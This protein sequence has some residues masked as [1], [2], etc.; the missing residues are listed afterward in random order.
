MD[1]HWQFLPCLNY[2]L[3]SKECVP[4]S[5]SGEAR[6]WVE[7]QKFAWAG[8][9]SDIRSL[10]IMASYWGP[11]MLD[12]VLGVQLLHVSVS[13]LTL[14][15]LANS[16][17]TKLS[18]LSS[19][20]KFRQNIRCTHSCFIPFFCSR[21]PNLVRG[22]ICYSFYIFQLRTISCFGCAFLIY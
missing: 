4:L 7:F 20:G 1:N 13:K 5:S 16:V 21:P 17:T 2:F 15:R 12:E 14:S 10:G 22:V 19:S 8:L 9:E 3:G 11:R 6:K 18:K